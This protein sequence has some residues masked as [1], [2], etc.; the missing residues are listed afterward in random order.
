MGYILNVMPDSP[1][2]HRIE[3]AAQLL[4]KGAVAV[5]PTDTGFSLVC[6]MDDKEGLDKNPSHPSAR[7]KKHLTCFVTLFEPNEPA[8]SS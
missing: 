3:Q 8:R 2:P 6:R 7:E 4:T 5:V 1:Q